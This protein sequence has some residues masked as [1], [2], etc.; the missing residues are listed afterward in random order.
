[1]AAKTAFRRDLNA[2]KWPCAARMEAPFA[3][4]SGPRCGRPEIPDF[5]MSPSKDDA[6]MASSDYE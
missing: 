4:Q 1:M 3:P 5:A 6:L 2:M